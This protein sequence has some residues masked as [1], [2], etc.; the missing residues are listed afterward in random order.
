M[1][2]ST[3]TQLVSNVYSKIK[4]NVVKY[5]N[6]VGRPLTLTEKILSGHLYEVPNKTLTGGKDYVFLKPD[7]VALQD[8][9]GQMV[10]LQFMQ[11]GLDQSVLPTTVHCDH[12]IRAEVQGDVDMKVSLDENSEVFKFLQSAAAKYGCGFWRPG[13][14]IIHQVVLE[15]YAFPGG[16]MIGTDSHTPNAGGLGMI[17]VGV[18]GLD[19]AETMAGLPWELLYP[20]KIGVKLTGELNGW[21]APKDII[22]KVAE[23]LTVSGGTNSIIEYF[24]PGTKSISCTGKATITNMGAEIGATC[25]IFP[26]DERMETYLKYTNR[27]EIAELANQNKELLVADPEV[28]TNPKK[29]F[30]KV[31]EINLSTLEPHIVGPH[32]PDLARAISKLGEDVKSNDYVDPISVALIGSCTNSSYEDM[33]RVAS[34]AQQAKEK[35]IKS[36][37]PLLITP[38]SE[39]IRGTIERDG[40]MDSL[41][42]IGA[43][44]L[45][46]AC[47][48]CIGQWNR[49]EL[50]N[51]EKNTIV[52]TFNRNFPGRNDGRRS[53]LNFIGSPEM[54]IAL[55]LGGKLSFNPLK[56]ELTASDGTKFKLEP[57]KPAPEV[58]ENGFMIPEGIFIAPP[59]DSNDIEVIIDPN[60]KR[61][62]LLE[63]FS[64]WDGKDFV[65]LPVLVKAKGKCTTDHISPAGA[66]LSL[67]GHLDNLSDNML[68]GAVNAFNDEVGKGKNILNSKL[69]TFSNI[70]RQY[71]EK[72]I[73]WMIVGD[74]N[75]GEGSSREH[76]AMSPRYLGCTAV[77]TK[78]FARI[79]ETN[80]KKQGILALTFSNPDDYDKILE[81][82]KI[83]LVDLNKLEPNTQVKCIISHANG[84][85]D[86][87]L[88]NHSYNK[89]QIE[90]F[91]NG[92]ALNVLRNNQ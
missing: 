14:G 28:E 82:D 20:K 18:G 5:R 6:V 76:A 39:Q 13:A 49:P 35:G 10:M 62:Q 53:T 88:L 3:T 4:E 64:K 80:L 16:L 83:S 42:Q 12:L 74:N 25:S 19:A 31:I 17:A 33:S 50:K 73:R 32:T 21:T 9:T 72:Q 78:S 38:G 90:W 69:E 81:D 24:G 56:D 71:K 70:A 55:A 87:F 23:E 48:P 45:A 67:R 84:S 37:I 51:D 60:S 58:P 8:V 75:Y 47:G 79:H 65:D 86:E 41:K 36:K 61:L 40:Q 43:T 26:Y 52:T 57:P 11:A 54:I 85:K 44:V 92:S 34:I 29:F 59:E 27:E 68:L 1:D 7:R 22:L 2:I 15:N 46:N 77:I 89:S 66:W 30:D 91:K 63:P